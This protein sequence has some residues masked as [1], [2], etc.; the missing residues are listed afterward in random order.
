[1]DDEAKGRVES[2]VD[3]VPDEAEKK[4]DGGKSAPVVR[5]SP[6]TWRAWRAKRRDGTY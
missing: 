3:S 5:S 2:A 4:G 6:T 1:V